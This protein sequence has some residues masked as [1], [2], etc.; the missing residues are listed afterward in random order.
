MAILQSPRLNEGGSYIERAAA[1]GRILDDFECSENRVPLRTKDIWGC[2]G[3]YTGGTLRKFCLQRLAN[4]NLP[5][6]FRV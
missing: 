2:Y 5:C 1:V 4:A 3:L 6:G